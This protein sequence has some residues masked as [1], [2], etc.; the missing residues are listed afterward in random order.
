MLCFTFIG[1]SQEVLGYMDKTTSAG[2][3][4]IYYS[5]TL[6]AKCEAI[7]LDVGTSMS[8]DGYDCLAAAIATYGYIV[9]SVDH[10]PGS[11]IKTDTF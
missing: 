7:V 2:Q 3:Y 6:S 1:V 8:R 10:Q 5:S 11:M 4:R 9:V